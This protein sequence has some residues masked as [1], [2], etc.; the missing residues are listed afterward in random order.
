MKM[1]PG[2]LQNI[3]LHTFTHIATEKDNFLQ[4]RAVTFLSTKFFELH[5]GKSFTI[6][7]IQNEKKK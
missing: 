2:H 1:C 5:I 3:P 6:K 7:T 4:I